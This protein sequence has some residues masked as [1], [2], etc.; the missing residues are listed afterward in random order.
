MPRAILLLSLKRDASN[1]T[2]W[3]Q[4]TIMTYFNR[5]QCTIVLTSEKDAYGPCATIRKK[6]TEHRKQGMASEPEQILG[7]RL[8]NTQRHL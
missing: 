3:S 4:P 1:A 6:V 2:L 8:A 7:L 5:K